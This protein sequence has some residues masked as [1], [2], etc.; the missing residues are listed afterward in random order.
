MKKIINVLVDESNLSQ[1]ALVGIS[2]ENEFDIN[3][4]TLNLYD[5]DSNHDLLQDLDGLLLVLLSPMT[6]SLYRGKLYQELVSNKKIE[7]FELLRDTMHGRIAKWSYCG[8]NT[9]TSFSSKV[10]LMTYVGVNSI[11]SSNSSVGNF[12]WIGN[13][14]TISP[15]V[16]IGNN[17]TIH[18]GVVIGSSAKIGK[19]NEVRNSI[20]PN[21]NLS[22]KAI[23]TDFY[24]STAYIHGL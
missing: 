12:C 17:V 20:E 24:G 6:F 14:V 2:L 18:D 16:V 23:E 22:S 3:V 7:S 8:E 19:F 5:L 1:N 15:G 4:I 21:S 10:G 13:N 9:K 11:I